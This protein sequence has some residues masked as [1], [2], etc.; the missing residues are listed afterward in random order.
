VPC[1]YEHCL[2]TQEGSDGTTCLTALTGPQTSEIKKDL[3]DLSMQLGSRIS[4]ARSRVTE[5]T[6]RRVDMRRYHDLQTV[7]TCAT[8]MCYSETPAQ[9]TT[10]RHGC[11]V[12]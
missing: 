12:M 8:V 6:T 4:K 11:S 1:S 3:A 10:H 5:P 9:L 2:L 7:Q